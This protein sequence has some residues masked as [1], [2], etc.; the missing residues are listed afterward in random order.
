MGV[1]RRVTGSGECGNGLSWGDESLCSFAVGK[2]LGQG[3]AGA[4]LATCARSLRRAESRQP[5][6]SCSKP[7]L[8]LLFLPPLPV[9]FALWRFCSLLNLLHKFLSSCLLWSFD[10]GCERLSWR[11][12]L[13]GML[14]KGKVRV[15]ASPHHFHQCWFRNAADAAASRFSPLP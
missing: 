6:N 10:V 8:V 4:P 2:A 12:V 7:S 3:S 14:P 13:K 1:W 5:G 9:R 15:Q 11:Q